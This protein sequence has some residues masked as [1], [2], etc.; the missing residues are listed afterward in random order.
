[1]SSTAFANRHIGLSND[2]IELMLKELGYASLDDL[3]SAVVPKRIAD[4][5]RLDLAAAASEEEALAELWELASKN[6]VLKARIGRGYYSTFTPK[7][8]QRNVLE[9]PAWYTA[10]TPYQPEISQGRLEVLFFFQTLITELTGLDIANASLLDEATAAAEAMTLAHRA[11][12]GKRN[13]FLVSKFCHPQTIQVLK[14]RAAPL[15]FNIQFIDETKDIDGWDDAFA[16]LLQYPNTCG[17]VVDL[18]PITA[19]AKDHGTLTIMATDLLALTLLK[20]PAELGADIAVGNSQRFGVPLGFGGPHAAFMAVTDSHKRSLPGRLVGQSI[21]VHGNP[22]YRLAL[23][24]R[25]Q[26]IRREK[27]TSN[28]CT[29]QALLAIMATL[30]AMYHGPDGLTKIATRVNSLASRFNTALRAAGISTLAS[31]DTLFD[32][33]AA[34][35]VDAQ[36]I[37]RNARDKGFNLSSQR[38]NQVLVSFDETST[39]SELAILLECFGVDNKD[40]SA[41]QDIELSDTAQRKDTFMQQREY[42][43][44]RSETEMMRYLRKLADR[45]IALDRSMIPLGS[46]TMKLNAASEMTPVTWPEFAQIHPLSP[47]DQVQ[48]YLEMIAQ[49]EKMLCASTGYDAMSLQPNAGSQGE[50]A[51]LLAIKGFH[52]ANGDTDRDVCL[53]PS[54]AHGTNPASAKMANMQV[55]V[56]RCDDNGNVD[57]QDLNAKID[58]NKG[59]IAAIMIT[60]P[61][62]H[63]VFEEHVT[64][65]CD[66][67]HAAGGQVYIDGAN[68]NALV[69][70]AQPGKFGGDVSHLNLHKTF[71]I[72]HGGGGPGVGP[73]GIGKHLEPFLPKDSH[74]EIRQGDAVSGAAFGSAG[75]LPI[76]WMYIRM[77][78]PGGLRRATQCAILSANYIAKRLS[79]N[80]P[81][82]F[83]GKSE[84]VAHECIIDTRGMKDFGVSVDDIAKRLIDFGFHAPTMSFPVAGTLMI[85]PT[86][87]ES[88]EELNRF[89]TAMTLIFD[90]YLAIKEGKINA[91]DSAL[92]HAPHTLDVLTTENFD[93]AY[94]RLEAV[95]PDPDM[96]H[97]NKYWPPVGRIDN[98]YGDKNLICSCPPMADYE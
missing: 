26:H 46:C 52:E 74:N 3:T 50:Y 14:T 92:H 54:S 8:I 19:Q 66:A 43:C 89:C 91:Q 90:E 37:I 56:V 86:E 95:Y 24:T 58:A 44:Y 22:A 64:E 93:R 39:E 84:L 25:E 51:G 28:I 27:A 63:G 61:S 97:N 13:T 9:N 33:V 49:L 85:E 59:R 82:L 36:E 17:Q 67:V 10:Y 31:S 71:C 21:D 15:G 96:R 48:G 1:M 72:P 20:T 73:I 81:I 7:V 23:Q 47:A 87:S 45:D 68:L 77:M 5:N 29:A 34:D 53:I 78:G 75:I 18:A 35:G 60:Y 62:T 2:E 88:L 12:K 94:S 65:V 11:L 55:V 83:T 16:I 57:L 30:Y 76:S 79:S 32:T 80:Y 42:H 6:K 4:N 69:G 38:D 40:I 41:S 70:V 98:V